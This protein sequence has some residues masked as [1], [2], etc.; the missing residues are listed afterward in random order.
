MAFKM[1][2]FKPHDMYDK[3]RADTHK[4]HLALKEKGYK[5]SPYKQYDPVKKPV[6]PYSPQAM[7]EYMEREVHNLDAK[8]PMNYHSF[9][10]PKRVKRPLRDLDDQRRPKAKKPSSFKKSCNCWKGHSRVPGTK[11]CAKGSC[12]K[13]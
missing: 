6:G 4:E 12:K 11:P 2:G 1:K 3:Q 9:Q 7:A 5:H 8:H 13:N 10:N